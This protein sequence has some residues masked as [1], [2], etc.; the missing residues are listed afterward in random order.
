MRNTQAPNSSLNWWKYL[1][2]S[3]RKRG[4]KKTPGP[5]QRYFSLLF[6]LDNKGI[7]YSFPIC[8][9]GYIP[10]YH[11]FPSCLKPHRRACPKKVTW[12]NTPPVFHHIQ[13]SKHLVFPGRYALEH[14]G[15]ALWADG[16]LGHWFDRLFLPGPN[17]HGNP[18]HIIYSPMG[19]YRAPTVLEPSGP[20]ST[21]TL[22]HFQDV[23]G[24]SRGKHE[25]NNAAYMRGRHGS[26]HHGA[27][28]LL[29]QS[30]ENWAFVARLG[31]QNLG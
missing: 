29:R 11:I 22:Q 21:G 8:Y 23:A 17:H 19:I 31:P 30:A 13:P 15:A 24:E 2:K 4:N 1:G 28:C 14:K 20:R 18:I 9:L 5:P 16:G 26:T 27:I 12:L 3:C 6:P 25:A 7:P 10:A